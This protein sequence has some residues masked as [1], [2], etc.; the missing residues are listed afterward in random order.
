MGLNLPMDRDPSDGRS[1]GQED[2]RKRNR[3]FWLR[4]S[5]ALELRPVLEAAL[6]PEREP[7]SDAIGERTGARPDDDPLARCC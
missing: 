5:I 3:L 1:G 2:G 7:D 4:R 6:I